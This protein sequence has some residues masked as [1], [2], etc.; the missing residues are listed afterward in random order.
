MS[1]V[2]RILIVDDHASV[3]D[4]IRAFLEAKTN[5][6]VCGEA[7]DGTS[8]ITEAK[9][10]KP[11]VIILDLALPRL[12]GVETASVLRS[13]LPDAKIVAFSMYA[14][15]LGRAIRSATK[16]DAVLPKSTSLTHLVATIQSLVRAQPPLPSSAAG[17]QTTPTA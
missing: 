16:I 17:P 12:N 3:R 13:N 9:L 4:G 5:F 10:L 15:E 14:S 6:I 8:A 2:T 7:E 1:T 11:D